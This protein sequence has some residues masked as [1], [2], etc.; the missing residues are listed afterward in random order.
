LAN[1]FGMSG[2]KTLLIDG[3]L[4]KRTLTRSLAP[5]ATSGLIE[6]LAG[7]Q[8][9]DHSIWGDK[10]SK[11]EFLPAVLNQPIPNSSDLLTS[12]AMQ[13]LLDDVRESHDFVLLDLPPLGALVDGRAVAPSLD[14]VIIVSEYGRT[15]VEGLAEA[16]QGLNIAQ[17]RVLGLVLNKVDVQSIRAYRQEAKGYYFN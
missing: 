14:A 10:N 11:F 7:T 6:V 13:R 2:L 4:R 16:L 12:V 17:A 5:H 15:P 1:L 9:I 3:D 8:S